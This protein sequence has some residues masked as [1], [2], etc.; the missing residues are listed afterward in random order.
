MM[1]KCE[2][3]RSVSAYHDDELPEAQRQFMA[4]HIS[5]CLLCAYELKQLRSLS[6]LLTEANRPQLTAGAMKQ[7]HQSVGKA[8]EHLVM[9]TAEMLTA[10]AATILIICTAWIWQGGDVSESVPPVPSAWET[11]AVT[12]KVD[13]VSELPPQLQFAQWLA[14]DLSQERNP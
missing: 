5:E 10:A 14:D 11:V 9:R 2:H 8:R 6:R 7:M 13:A 1:T 3:S 12:Q 4:S